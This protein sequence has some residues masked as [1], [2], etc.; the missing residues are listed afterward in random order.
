MATLSVRTFKSIDGADDVLSRVGPAHSILRRVPERFAAARRPVAALSV[1]GRSG[2]VFGLALIAVVVIPNATASADDSTGRTQQPSPEQQLVDRHAPIVMVKAQSGPC[3]TSG[4]AFEPASVDIVLDNPQVFV[5]QLG[6]QNPVLKNAPSAT[7]LG[8]LGAAFYLDYPGNALDPGCV[9]EED[10]ERYSAGST[11]TV[12][13]HI[14]TEQ[15]YPGQLVVQY[16]FWWYFNDWNNT[17][18][19]DWEMIQIVFDASTVEEALTEPPVATG[20]AQHEG[21]ERADW[22]S[23]KL[24]RDGDRPV[25]YP[26]AGSHASYYSS[27]HFLGRGAAEGFGCDSTEGPSNTLRP[28]AVLLPDPFDATDEEFG[29]LAF[30]GHWGERHDGAFNGPTGPADKDQWT[31]PISFQNDLRDSSVTIPG[32][33]TFGDSAINEFCSAVG[34]GSGLLVTVKSSPTRVVVAL[35]ILLALIRLLVR[36]TTWRPHVDLPLRRTRAAGQILRGAAII[37]R[38]LARTFLMIGLVYVPVG[39]VAAAA[40][41]LVGRIGPVDALLDLATR[42]SVVGGVFAAVL[43]GLG[44]LLGFVV[45]SAAVAATLDRTGSSQVGRTHP[46]GLVAARWRDLAS[47]ILRAT[48]IVIVL[49]V[50]IVGIPWGVRQLVRYQLIPQV[51][52]LEGLGGSA[53]LRRSSDL[54]RRRWWHTAA[55]FTVLNLVTLIVGIVT[56]MLL[57]IG[58]SSLPLWSFNVMAA[59]VFGLIVP[60]TAVAYALIYGDR[61][62]HLEAF[63]AEPGQPAL[64]DSTSGA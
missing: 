31:K 47:A 24:E 9:Y 19:S 26:S 2:F 49:L 41:H 38:R 35:I 58:L 50:S 45:V 8:E 10:F 25:V 7:D 59:L 39:V 54:I 15:E 13:A 62:A 46:Y 20:F 36:S 64:T 28:D 27:A 61:V 53:A 21:G 3:D 29:W 60:Y 6:T 52:M 32:G 14:V 30:A 22:N 4:E 12:Y 63:V 16:W 1:R 48:A 5:R 37:Y 40:V 11:P 44:N 34:W 17:H 23:E 18:E 51:V 55:L 42:N 57:L 43:G 56:A 33:G